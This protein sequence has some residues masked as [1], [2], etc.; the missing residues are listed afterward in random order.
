MTRLFPEA[1]EEAE[2]AKD[3]NR[4]LKEVQQLRLFAGFV[5]SVVSNPVGAYSTPALEGIFGMMRDKIAALPNSS[6]DRDGV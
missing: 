2:L 5:E 3:Y 1:A 4:L 6:G